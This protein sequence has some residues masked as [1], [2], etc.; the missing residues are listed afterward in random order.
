MVHPVSRGNRV[1]DG[2]GRGVINCGGKHS[3]I[4]GTKR[5][6]SWKCHKSGNKTTQRN[7]FWGIQIDTSQRK[8]LYYSRGSKCSLKKSVTFIILISTFNICISKTHKPFNWSLI[9]WE[10][11]VIIQSQI[12]S[13]APSFQVTLDSLIKWKGTSRIPPGR[14]VLYMGPASNPGREYCNYPGE[15]YC[16]YWGCETISMG[17]KVQNPDKYL[18]VERG[19]HGCI[20]PWI[21][22]SGEVTYVG[23]C[24]FHYINITQSQ[25]PGWLLGRSW[26]LRVW[27]PGKDRGVHIL[28]KKEM[29]PHDLGSVGPNPV[30]WRAV[31]PKVRDQ[32]N[33]SE[34]LENS[35]QVTTTVEAPQEFR[36]EALWKI[37]QATF[38]VLNDTHPNL[39]REFGY[40]ITLTHPFMR[41]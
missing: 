33:H 7:N 5:S 24:K 13:G 26:G 34:K 12:T 20:K 8:S 36:N 11:Q 10:D 37:L 40:A 27:E 41:P 16:R 19:P 4:H 38:K 35:T 2:R 9:L 31:D 3:N 14:K 1:D 32:N 39:T 30:V 15:F 21:G 22:P 29:V 18:K 28:I 25:D 17:W 23:T 6:W